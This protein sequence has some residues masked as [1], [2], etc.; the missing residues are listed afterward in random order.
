MVYEVKLRMG[1]IA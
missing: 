1:S